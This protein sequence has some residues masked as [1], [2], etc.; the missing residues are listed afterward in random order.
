MI[1]LNKVKGTKVRHQDDPDVLFVFAGRSALKPGVIYTLN[2]YAN[3]S[4]TYTV[5][6]KCI[7]ANNLACLLTDVRRTYTF[8]AARSLAVDLCPRAPRP[9]RS[10]GSCVLLLNVQTYNNQTSALDGLFSSTL[11]WKS[12][13]VVYVMSTVMRFKTQHVLQP[14]KNEKP[15][16]FVYTHVELHLSNGLFRSMLK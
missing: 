15:V 6:H 7:T 9:S 10:G 12:T 5:M 3:M 1:N 16:W 8:T 4:N 14:L 13:T 11:E 2:M